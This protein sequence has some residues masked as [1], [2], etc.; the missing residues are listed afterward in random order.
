M[1]IFG[2]VSI[3]DQDVIFPMTCLICKLDM[4]SLMCAA[5]NIISS[6]RNS[7]AKEMTLMLKS[8]CQC[9]DTHILTSPIKTTNPVME[10]STYIIT[11]I[12]A[13]SFR[14]AAISAK[15]SPKL[16]IFYISCVNM[17]TI[18]RVSMV[19]QKVVCPNKELYWVNMTRI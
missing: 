13:R 8:I 9:D 18:Y 10:I 4:S 2:R 1:L 17:L 15:M 6:V 16:T 14:L 7:H 11:S 19:E 3:V 5:D 12:T